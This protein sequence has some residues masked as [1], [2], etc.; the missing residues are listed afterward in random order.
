MDNHQRAIAAQVL[1]NL[2]KS[3]PKSRMLEDLDALFVV[4]K[5]E[6]SVTAWHSPQSLW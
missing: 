5:D 2:A 1:S 6:R 4:R 3:D